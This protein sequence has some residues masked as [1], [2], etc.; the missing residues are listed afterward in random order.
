MPN[1]IVWNVKTVPDIRL[2]AEAHGHSDKSDQEIR[3][4]IGDQASSPIYRSIV[5]LVW[6]IA[7]FESDRWIIDSV[8]AWHI[9][10]RSEKEIIEEF[11]DMIADVE[12]RLV[13][14]DGST[15]LQYRAMRYRLATPSYSTQPCN[16]YA[17]DDMSL[18]D[19]LSPFSNRRI[20][21][22]ELS[23]VLGL[24]YDSLQDD[25]VEK[26]FRQRRLREIAEYCEREVATIFRIW[27]RYELYNGRLSNLGFRQSEARLSEW[28]A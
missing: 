20:T 18:C 12:P 23:S 26:Y 27:L 19:V 14:F 8:Y 15:I 22:R 24:E 28:S 21:L 11:F 3:D 16:L 2:F 1:L 4:A 5:C 13:T 10:T 9:A 7:H 25:E 6:L 17:I